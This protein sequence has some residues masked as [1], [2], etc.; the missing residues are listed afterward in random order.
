VTDTVWV[1][2]ESK[3]LMITMLASGEGVTAWKTARLQ[4]SAISTWKFAS[5][6]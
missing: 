1:L 4:G 3:F 6:V 2:V 5:T